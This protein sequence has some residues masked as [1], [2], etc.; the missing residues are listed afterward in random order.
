VNTVDRAAASPANLLGVAD[1]G[2]AAASSEVA[3]P[4][5]DVARN[6]RD[7]PIRSPAAEVKSI[8]GKRSIS[9]YPQVIRMSF[10]PPSS[11]LCNRE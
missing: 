2:A 4:D 11:A 5:G 9:G 3:S 1:N 10:S 8:R 7:I 6:Q